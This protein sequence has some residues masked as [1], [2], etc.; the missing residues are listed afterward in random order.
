MELKRAK[1]LYNCHGCCLTTMG[2]QVVEAQ[3]TTE[4]DRT[5][6]SGS[7]RKEHL[8]PV[9]VISGFFR[10]LE[11][12][13]L[14]VLIIISLFVISPDRMK[15]RNVFLHFSLG[16]GDTLG[17]LPIVLQS[18]GEVGWGNNAHVN[19]RTYF[20]LPNVAW[21]HAGLYQHLHSVCI[22]ICTYKQTE[23]IQIYFDIFLI[24]VCI[25]IYVTV[26]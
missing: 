8:C 16:H 19:L 17:T 23:Y 18:S 1:G 11:N 4:S 13:S 9:V 10:F 12:F 26:V 6:S 7:R 22:C 2:L 24:Y 14:L 20:M 15:L 21:Q 25:Y 3:D 5:P